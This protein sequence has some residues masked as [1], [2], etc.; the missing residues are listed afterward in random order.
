[1]RHHSL[2]RLIAEA[3]PTSKKVATVFLILLTVLMLWN[4]IAGIRTGT[5][6][7]KIGRPISRFRNPYAFWLEVIFWIFVVT[8]CVVAIVRTVLKS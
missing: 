1:M 8:V 6:Y 4:V 7:D 5:I 2:I 3:Q